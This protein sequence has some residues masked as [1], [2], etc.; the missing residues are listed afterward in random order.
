[1]IRHA[2]LETVATVCAL[3]VAMIQPPFGTLLMPPISGPMLLAPR[4]T[5]ALRAAVALTAI[6]AS[7]NPEHRPAIGVAAKPKP[8]NNF[9]MNRH[10][11]A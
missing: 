7:A 4:L 1:M 2:A 8:Q 5:P 9:L 6:T 10:P 3:A 11:R